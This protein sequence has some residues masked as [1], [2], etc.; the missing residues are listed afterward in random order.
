MLSQII[1]AASLLVNT[2]VIDNTNDVM[3]EDNRI[4]SPIVVR[5]NGKIT[6]GSANNFARDMYEA[7]ATGQ[8]IIPIVISSYG[9]SIYALFEMIDVIK[10][11]KNTTEVATIITGKAMSAGAVLASFGN[12]GLR[13]ITPTTTMMIHEV[14]SSSKG[15]I[16]EIKADAKETDRLNK[17][18]L[19]MMSIN[20]GKPKTYIS[21]IVHS[22]GHADWYLSAKDALRHGIVDKIGTPNLQIKATTTVT[23]E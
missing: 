20:I 10:K 12:N 23:L 18:F 3:I 8:P 6:E 14:S 7:Q 2:T 16:G 19:T 4:T 22:K 17:I 15:K 13:F 11:I 21:T 5:V 9:G 1:L